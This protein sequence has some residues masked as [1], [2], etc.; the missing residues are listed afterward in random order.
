MAIRRPLFLRVRMAEIKRA[1]ER[2][3]KCRK[4]A[5]AFIY[6]ALTD[7]GYSNF[8]GG[9]EKALGRAREEIEEARRWEDRAWE[10]WS[11]ASAAYGAAM[12]PAPGWLVDLRG[13]YRKWLRR[14]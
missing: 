3:R 10:K 9:P 12:P 2:A 7:S 4:D 6:D 8:C 14:V 5:R 13:F 1:A 11:K